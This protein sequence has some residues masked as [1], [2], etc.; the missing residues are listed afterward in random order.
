MAA[1]ELLPLRLNVE[2]DDSGI[3]SDEDRVARARLAELHQ[4][5]SSSSDEEPNENDVNDPL[6]ESITDDFEK[7]KMMSLR[8][9]ERYADCEIDRSSPQLFEVELTASEEDEDSS[10]LELVIPLQS[11]RYKRV[12]KKSPWFWLDVFLCY[13]CLRLS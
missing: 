4:N 3:D 8:A 7:L 12:P 1:D 11:S 10:V 2:L 6:L 5:E 9:A 13:C